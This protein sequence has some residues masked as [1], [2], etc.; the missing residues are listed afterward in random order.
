MT[1]ARHITIASLAVISTLLLTQTGIWAQAVSRFPKG[2]RGLAEGQTRPP[3]GNWLLDANDDGERFR[4]L[5]IAAGGT[6]QQMWQ[7]GYR[8]EQV[9]RAIV[10]ENWELGLHH[11]GKLRAVFNVALMKRP[12]RTPNAEAIFLDTNWALL[13]AALRSRD[14]DGAREMLL[15][16]RQACMSCHIAERMEFLNNT[17]LFRNTASFPAK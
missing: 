11:W 10:D 13:E 15:I 16:E 3:G 14:R 8:Y 7:I 6:D 2:I 12:N 5:Q 4:R 1:Y 17:P 9:Y